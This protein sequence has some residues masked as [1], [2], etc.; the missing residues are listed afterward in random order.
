MEV[1]NLQRSSNKNPNRSFPRSL[2]RGFASPPSPERPEPNWPC[3]ASSRSPICGVE[4][5]IGAAE[6]TMFGMLK[7]VVQRVWG[8]NQGKHHGFSVGCQWFEQIDIHFISPLKS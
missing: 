3:S 8:Q 2:R 7:P 5:M 4:A 1:L 6:T